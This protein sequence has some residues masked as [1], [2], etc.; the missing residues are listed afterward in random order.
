MGTCVGLL[1]EE[2][3]GKGGVA[4]CQECDIRKGNI[5]AFRGCGLDFMHGDCLL[6]G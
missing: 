3:G 6:G 5:V 1:K 4:F 2:E